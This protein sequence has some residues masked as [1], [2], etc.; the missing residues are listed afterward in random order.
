META[1]DPKCI[2]CHKILI[3]KNAID[4]GYCLNCYN[5]MMADE[6]D[7]TPDINYDFHE[8]RG[9]NNELI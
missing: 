8:G 6:D 3:G 4:V 9:E 7:D 1:T 5:L 2:K